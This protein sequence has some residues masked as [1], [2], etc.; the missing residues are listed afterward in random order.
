MSKYGNYFTTIFKGLPIGKNGPFY[1]TPHNIPTPNPIHARHRTPRVPD[2][3]AA[4]YG[5]P[6]VES[7]GGG[8]RHTHVEK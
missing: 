4:R 3:E 6:K 7:A 2:T 8:S 1:H 5:T